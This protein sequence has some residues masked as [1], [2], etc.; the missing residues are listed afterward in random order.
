VVSTGSTDEGG[1]AT[2]EVPGSAG[3]VPGSAGEGA[4]RPERPGRYQR[5]PAGM[6]GALIVTVLV[7]LAFV[8]F[9]ALNRSD[10]VVKPERVDYLTE[11]RYA[12]QDGQAPDLVYPAQ[13]PAGWYATN[14]SFSSGGAAEIELSMLTADGEY[15]GFVQSPASV[16][17]LLTTY[18]DPHPQSGG[19]IQVSGSAASRW[20]TWT[21]AGGDT[22]LAT[23]HGQDALLVFGTVSE[24][25]LQHLAARLT[26]RP[27]EIRVSQR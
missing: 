6:V 18:V 3:E 23:E 12:Q 15:V 10:L 14:V 8:A 5:S 7:I 1:A 25:Q 2:G 11:V 17:E 13:L 27:V 21:D 22:A 24:D 4:T 16:P 26:T 20:N 19:P 9:R